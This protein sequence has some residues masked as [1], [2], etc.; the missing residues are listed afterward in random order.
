MRRFLL[1]SLLFASPAL[2]DRRTEEIA[3]IA[4]SAADIITTEIWLAHDPYTVDGVEHFPTEG[5]PI[6]AQLGSF[7]SSQT[8]LMNFPCI[9]N[10]SAPANSLQDSLVESLLGMCRIG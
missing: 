4:A 2:A 9:V 8:D 1:L 3:V 7:L 6:L 10:C 5:G